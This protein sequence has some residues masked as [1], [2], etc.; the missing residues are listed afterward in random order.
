M[1]DVRFP[2]LKGLTIICLLIFHFACTYFYTAPDAFNSI[3]LEIISARY[4]NPFFH[5][6]WA[7]FA[8]GL[9]E[10]NAVIEVSVAEG[11]WRN[12]SQE[13]L[14]EHYSFRITENGRL[15]LV[16]SG[17]AR[18]AAWECS[19]GNVDL[20]DPK[21]YQGILKDICRNYLRLENTDELRI[22][23]TIF[24]LYSEKDGEFIF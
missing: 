13:V 22:R 20:N 17:M 24:D 21:K 7:L 12:I 23:L 15:A 8:P 9:P 19:V 3:K 14:R 16:F 2:Y 5:Q 10:Y 4:I 1:K 6:Y 18:W 11:D